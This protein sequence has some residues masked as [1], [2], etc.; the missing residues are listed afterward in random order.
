[1]SGYLTLPASPTGDV[2]ALVGPRLLAGLAHGPGLFEHRALWPAPRALDEAQLLSVLDT[3]GV[4]G[5]G[6]AGFPFARKVRTAVESGRRRAVVVNAS[7]GEPA[8]AKDSTLL[9]AA[10]HL[11]LDGAEAVAHALGC[12][13][14]QVVVGHDRPAARRALEVALDERD[15]G[16]AAVDVHLTRAPFVGGQ[17][18]AV[19]ELLEGRENLP[20]T[21]WEPAA[22]SGLRGRPTL[23]S[24]AETFAQVAT[25]LALGPAGYA[26][27]GTPGE[28]GTTLLTVAGDGPHGVVLEVPYGVGLGSVLEHCGYPGDGPVL[29]GGYHGTWLPAGHAPGLPVSR[30]DLAPVG[31]TLGAGV[32]LPLAA[33]TC[34]IT[35][36]AGV[37]GYLAGASAGRCGPCVNGLPALATAVAALADG[38][39]PAAT[40]RVQELVGLLPGR[41][42]CAHPDGSARLV[43]SLLRAFPDEV[44]A[45]EQGVCSATASAPTGRRRRH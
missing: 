45:H 11:V 27:L 2:A 42:A 6:G 9:V 40:R 17:E 26:E 24:N 7:E 38:A 25:L 37:T 19:L 31:L 32:V 15:P 18:S 1:M 21:R 16:L 34:P 30:R 5:R 33:S 23:V 28:P 13:L 20:V 41:G 12:D 29:L 39:G 10:P 3:A 43:A 22:V 44:R 4:Q 35:V 8:S 14:V 36:T